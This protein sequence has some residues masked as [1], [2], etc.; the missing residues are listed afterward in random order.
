M[1]NGEENLTR[2]PNPAKND[3]DAIY[4]G[5]GEAPCQ[6]SPTLKIDETIDDSCTLS[7]ISIRVAATKYFR[8]CGS[9]HFCQLRMSAVLRVF[10]KEPGSPT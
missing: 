7:P 3:L 8:I 2:L 1:A 10:H 9:A 4:S 6:G 5:F